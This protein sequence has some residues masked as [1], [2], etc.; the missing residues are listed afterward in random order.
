MN[1]V[2]KSNYRF[3][4]ENTTDFSGFDEYTVYNVLNCQAL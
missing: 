2:E 3:V 4:K 1:E